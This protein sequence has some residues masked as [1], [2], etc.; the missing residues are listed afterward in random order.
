MREATKF[1]LAQVEYQRKIKTFANK[2][3]RMIPGYSSEDLQSE[4]LEVLW[5]CVNAYDPNRGAGFNTLFWR[6]AHNRL[7]SLHR[8]Y[9]S[10]KRAI[11]FVLLDED[12]FTYVVDQM[13][14]EF[15]AEDV[16]IGLEEV[17]IRQ[18][19]IGRYRQVRH[20]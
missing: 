1:E 9:A 3:Y 20:A 4:M 10:K 15:S 18:Q 11:E 2:T 17:R 6:S 12:E 5:K 7:R 16:F 8:F 19:Q 13:V 14:S